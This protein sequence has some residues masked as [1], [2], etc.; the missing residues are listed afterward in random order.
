MIRYAYGTFFKRERNREKKKR[1]ALKRTN[2]DFSFGEIMCISDA[3][4][5]MNFFV[6]AQLFDCVE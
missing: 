3:R 4:E 1:A 6:L 5:E 2:S